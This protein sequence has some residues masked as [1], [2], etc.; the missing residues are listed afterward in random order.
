M[1]SFEK[2]FEPITVKGLTIP[3]RLVVS[4]MLTNMANPDGTVDERFIRYH[5]E[6]AKGG[7]GLVITENCT[8][9]PEAGVSKKL[10]GLYTDEQVECLRKLT[11]RVHQSG[12]RIIAQ[13]YHAGRATTSA[14]TGKQIV[15]PSAIR[16]IT[17]KEMPRELTIDEIQELVEQFGNAAKR[18]QEAG[19]DGVEIHGASGYLIS[20]FTSPY[21]NKR[22]DMYGG[23]TQG[24]ARFAVEIVKCV[25]ER[26]GDA[27]PIFYRLATN[28][29][30][31]GGLGV[32]E[33]KIIARMLEDAGVD[34]MHCTQGIFASS[35]Y[36]TAPYQIEKGS[37]IHNAAEIKK[38]L[39]IPVIAVGGHVNDPAMA[40]TMLMSGFADMI[41]MAR[42][43]L[44][45]PHLPAKAKA[46]NVEDIITCIGC[47]QGC[48]G[49]KP[50]GIRCLVN[51]F[52]G[53]ETELR[54]QSTTEPKKVLVVGGGISGCE[55]AIL[56]AKQ[57][58][59]VVLIEKENALGGQWRVACIP[60]GKAEFASLLTWQQTQLN[61]LGVQIRLQTELTSALL[62]EE[63]PDILVNA[64]GSSP[65]VPPV[66]GL[67]EN[68]VIAHDVLKGIVECGN[69]VAV[70]GGGLVGAETAEFLAMQGKQVVIVEMLPDIAKEASANPRKLLLRNLKEHNVKVY[71]NSKVM[72][73]EEHQV[74]FEKD[75]VAT[76]LQD[77]DTVVIA[78]GCKANNLVEDILSQYSGRIVTIGDAAKAKNGIMNLQE[79]AEAACSL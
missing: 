30:V 56:A 7:W 22:T 71:T 43:S 44:A 70:I 23:T 57:G 51:P 18:A 77:I 37:L 2:I 24:R 16:D 38:V 35:E 28:E 55:F 17:K 39:H 33:T 46:G 9:S 13:I 68:G 53:R 11:E 20:Q 76:T 52:T 8:V 29:Y 48:Q 78:T 50:N 26:V 65:F 12:G 42:A 19:F 4:A 49:P 14:V 73:V 1:Q 74:T 3:N 64:I 62:Q 54:L 79:A 69:R 66:A 45:D 40:E 34:V 10:P 47:V 32:E 15:A 58:Y 60:N 36:I 25:R 61:K 21:S 75:G 6:K 27:Y 72:E 67:R 63:K 41:V 59:E 31:D 5:E